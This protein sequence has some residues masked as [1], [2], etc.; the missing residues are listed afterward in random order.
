MED[1]LIS[2]KEAAKY[3]PRGPNGKL[4]SGE[5]VR[6]RMRRKTGIR[7]KHVYDETSKKYYTTKRWVAEFFAAMT[8]VENT[9]K[10]TLESEQELARKMEQTGR[11]YGFDRINNRRKEKKKIK[12]I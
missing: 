1:R 9:S 2:P 7:L 11:K 8:V 10:I 6:S 3:F 4:L 5:A 12:D